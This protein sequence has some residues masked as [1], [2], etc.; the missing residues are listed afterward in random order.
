M[1]HVYLSPH[2]DDAVL[3]CGGAIHYRTTNGE[4]VAVITVLAGTL[5]SGDPSPFA[6]LQHEY[7]GNPPQPMALRRAE[8]KAALTLLGA[9][10]WHL[11]YL[12]AVYRSGPAREWLYPEEEALWAEVHP[13]D[14]L[15]QSEAESL[16][17]RLVQ[18]IPSGDEVTVYAPMGV[19]HH[20]DH[21]IVHSAGRRLL[22]RR[23][24]VAFYEDYPYAEKPGATDLVL[25]V[26][27]AE[28]WCVECLPLRAADVAAKTFALAY[29]HSQ[30]SI[31]FGGTKTMPNRIWTFATSRCPQA[32]LAE[33]IWWPSG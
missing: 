33:R 13:A 17:A 26:P 30:V 14:P 2:L 9:E 12:D 23:Y 18:V 29:Y 28:Q 24:R 3:S 8:D 6:R 22:K 21:Q 19:G 27:E 32:G 20:V 15:G 1:R 5:E 4:P 11:E 7:W 10:A 31:L 16:V 25:T